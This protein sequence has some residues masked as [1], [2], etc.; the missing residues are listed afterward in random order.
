MNLSK[1]IPFAAVTFIIGGVASM[2]LP[3]F[4]GF[5]AELQV[6]IGAWQTFP[7]FAILAGVGILI[8]VAYTLRA[9]IKGFFAEAAVDSNSHYEPLPPI[10]LPERLGAAI[11]IATTVLIGIFP[12]LLLDVIS[13][14]WNSGLMQH[15]VKGG[16]Q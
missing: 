8:G 3:G 11:L 14:S 6:L 16:G 15:L 4:S 1:A 9:V 5:I 12:R 7:G 2:G 10:S 13:P